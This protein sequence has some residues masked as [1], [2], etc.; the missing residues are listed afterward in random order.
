MFE[1]TAER[2]GGAGVRE[3]TLLCWAGPSGP[4]QL[5]LPCLPGILRRRS[6]DA[7]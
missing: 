5:A 4:E 6:S 1:V 7:P 3:P 2:P